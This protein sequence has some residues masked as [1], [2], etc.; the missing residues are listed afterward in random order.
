MTNLFTLCSF[1]QRLAPASSDVAFYF[2]SDDQNSSLTES[3]LCSWCQKE[4]SE[5]CQHIDLGLSIF[6][7]ALPGQVNSID[8]VF[9]K[10]RSAE[11]ASILVVL[12]MVFDLYFPECNSNLTWLLNVE[13]SV[14]IDAK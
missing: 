7:K 10:Q 13:L 2:S 11:K 12:W 4:S 1:V 14:V 9:A 8:H 6:K 5:V 3:S